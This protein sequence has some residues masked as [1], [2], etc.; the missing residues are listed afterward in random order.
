MAGKL[1]ATDKAADSAKLNGQPSS[2][3]AEKAATDS[4]LAN[5]ANKKNVSIIA[6]PVTTGV[7]GGYY[8]KNEFGEVTI[9]GLIELKS[10]ASNGRVLA[11]LPVGFRPTTWVQV[12][13]IGGSSINRSCTLSIGTTGVITLFDRTGATTE[14]QY[15]VPA[16]SY[17]GW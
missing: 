8:W 12:P 15:A 16:V 2:Y 10:G 4:M 6:L 1:G 7:T 5:K 11:N 13:V 3:Y 9:H 14:M 17:L